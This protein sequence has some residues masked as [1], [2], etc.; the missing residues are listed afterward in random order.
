MG[1][2]DVDFGETTQILAISNK[3]KHIHTPSCKKES[4]E[5]DSLGSVGSCARAMDTCEA[6][7]LNVHPALLVAELSTP[8]TEHNAPRRIE[9]LRSL[10]VTLAGL[11]WQARLERVKDAMSPGT[12]SPHN[13][14]PVRAS[15]G[16]PARGGRGKGSLDRRERLRKTIYFTTHDPANQ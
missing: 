6:S 15:Y 14:A 16:E 1:F 4:T 13:L 3:R 7:T 11:L 2:V 12:A 5:R 10:A 8:R 9:R